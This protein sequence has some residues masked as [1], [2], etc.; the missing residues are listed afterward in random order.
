[1]ASTSDQKQL[2]TPTGPYGRPSPYEEWIA[3]TGV[4]IHRGY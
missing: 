3:S 1:M 4:P 2:L